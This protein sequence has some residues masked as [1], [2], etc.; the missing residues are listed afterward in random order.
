MIS[1]SRELFNLADKGMTKIQWLE[2]EARQ[3]ETEYK[4]HLFDSEGNSP[5]DLV[6]SPSL[7]VFKSRLGV[8]L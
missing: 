1:D 3:I 8:C 7:E 4:A 2:V 6:D 5:R